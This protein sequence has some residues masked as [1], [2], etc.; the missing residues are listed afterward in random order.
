[1]TNT[2]IQITQKLAC[3]PSVRFDNSLHFIAILFYE[4]RVRSARFVPMFGFFTPNLYQ[5]LKD[6]LKGVAGAYS[7]YI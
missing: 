5:N 3:S 1:M 7:R 2:F 6:E 4:V